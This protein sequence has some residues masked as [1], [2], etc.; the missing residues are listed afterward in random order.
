MPILVIDCDEP[1]E[2]RQE[3]AIF[4]IMSVRLKWFEGR[5][6]VLPL[7]TTA[8]QHSAITPP[9]TKRTQNH[10]NIALRDT[11][12]AVVASF[13]CRFAIAAKDSSRVPES[14]PAAISDRKTSLNTFGCLGK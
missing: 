9:I 12:L 13:S 10:K 1:P 6:T 14:S 5:H 2:A 11:G 8:E 4:T 7:R 3:A